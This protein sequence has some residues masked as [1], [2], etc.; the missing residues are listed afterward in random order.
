M[1]FT[2]AFIHVHPKLTKKYNQYQLKGH[3][4]KYLCVLLWE[5]IY[6]YIYISTELT[7]YFH[8]AHQHTKA[9]LLSFFFL[10]KKK[11]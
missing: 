5:F 11:L 10:H 4:F 7:K 9:L 1:Y 2:T 3:T 6:I 8:T